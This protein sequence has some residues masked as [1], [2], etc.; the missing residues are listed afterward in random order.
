M[1]SNKATLLLLQ[2]ADEALLAVNRHVDL[3]DKIDA[4]MFKR[5]HLE[6]ADLILTMIALVEKKSVV[7]HK[8]V[9]GKKPLTLKG[10]Q[11]SDFEI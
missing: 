8:Y 5:Y 3:K 6:A 4:A 9:K 2:R 1:K 11:K 10:Y 7:Q